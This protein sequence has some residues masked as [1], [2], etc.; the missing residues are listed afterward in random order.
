MND[1]SLVTPGERQKRIRDIFVDH[2]NH[3]QAIQALNHFYMPVEGG[4]HSRG[5]VCALIGPSRTGK[6]FAAN[7]IVAAH[8]PRVGQDGIK[9]PVLLVDCPIEGG[10]RGILDSIADA[11]ELTVSSRMTN[12]NLINVILRELRRAEVEFVIFDEAQELFPE[13]NKRIL[14]FARGLLRKML[15]LNRFNIACIG[16]PETYSIIAED[17]QLLGRGGLEHKHLSPYDWNDEHD[18]KH[19]R[20]MCHKFDLEMPFEKSGFSAT[21]FAYR[22]FQASGGCIGHLKNYLIDAG[23]RAIKDGS[24]QV[25]LRHFADAFDARRR[26]GEIFNPFRVSQG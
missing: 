21:D 4:I 22:L 17:P 12:A 10:P 9:R 7:D 3:Q 19:F 11:L 20:A 23:N 24:N 26:P 14:A 2:R 25:E 13:K 5:S 6:S 16:L 15:N 8:E 18:R 1:N